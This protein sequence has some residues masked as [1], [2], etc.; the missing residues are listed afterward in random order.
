MKVIF[1]DFDG[2]IVP[3][4]SWRERKGKSERGWKPCVDALNH[5]TDTTG[6][7]IVVSSTW[8]LGEEVIALR[9]LLRGWG[10]TGSVVGKTP[11]LTVSETDFR[12]LDR[13]HEIQWW[14]DQRG[15]RRGDVES[16]VILDDDSDM[17]HLMD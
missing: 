13:G 7:V 2:V 5:I 10:V 9:E 15:N 1:L 4:H 11:R 17:A 14:L 3:A 16:F 12:E 8:R 6:A